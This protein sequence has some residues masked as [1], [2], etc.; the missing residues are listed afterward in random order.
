MAG[1][2]LRYPKPVRDAT[3]AFM[4][5]FDLFGPSHLTALALTLLAC[6]AMIRVSPTLVVSPIARAM[7]YALL[8]LVIVK[9]ILYIFV[10]DWPWTN[11]LPLALCRI[12]EFLVIYMLLKR[13]YRVFE[14]AYFLAI[15][16]I[17]ALLTPDLPV[18]F[19]DLRFLLFFVS[20]GLSVVAVL[21]GISGYGFRPTLRSV[22][23]VFVFLASYTVLIAI[24]NVLLDANYLFLMQKPEGAS[25]LDYL[26][27]W[28][29]YVFAMIGVAVVL[30]LLCYLPF[31]FFEPREQ[32]D[33]Q[34]ATRTS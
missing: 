29:I 11:S 7:A 32:D 9:P 4:P 25:I 1:L 3:I 21:Y 18:D 15:G 22:G 12:N 30:C 2:A 10:Y 16:S 6:V 14:I 5:A 33:R 26:G 27:P 31:A 17:F 19:P 13:S 8:V 23:R 20:H 24:L 34:Q 28:P